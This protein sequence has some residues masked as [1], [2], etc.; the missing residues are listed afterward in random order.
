[1]SSFKN[2]KGRFQEGCGL[3]SQEDRTGDL[4]WKAS[5]QAC[6]SSFTEVVELLEKWWAKIATDENPRIIFVLFYDAHKENMFTINLED[7]CEAPSKASI[8]N[9]DIKSRQMHW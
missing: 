5:K 2:N 8:T 9:N 1:L 3:W 6:F 7:G 4:G